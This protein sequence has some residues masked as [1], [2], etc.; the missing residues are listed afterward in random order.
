MFNFGNDDKEKLRE[1]MEQIKQ[2][3]D[4]GK[5][6]GED[7]LE[8]FG[9]ESLEQADTESQS[10]EGSETQSFQD[11]PA[12]QDKDG[13]LEEELDEFEQK[14]GGGDGQQDSWQEPEEQA[15]QAQ[16]V[17]GT[18]PNT[19]PPNQNQS[20]TTQSGIKDSRD[21]NQLSS[22]LPAPPQSREIDVPEIDRGPLFLKQQKFL[23]AKKMVEDM[24]Y[25]ADD[26]ER[27]VNDLEVGLQEDQE[28]E[29]EVRTI[30]M[31]FEDDRTAVEDVISPREE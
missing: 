9:E 1:N 11:D 14:F 2:L 26:M 18:P 20:R 17:D 21:L 6:V 8:D 23:R 19:T 28:I 29:R 5:T 15:P 30:L 16:P 24:L 4:E 22:E 25:L 10:L 31:E 3:V 13:A 27:T 12:P 7:G